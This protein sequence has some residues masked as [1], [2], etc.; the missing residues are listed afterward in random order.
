[1]PH[2]RNGRE[3]QKGDVVWLRATVLEVYAS[4]TACNV[5]VKIHAPPGEPEAELGHLNTKSLYPG[6]VEQFTGAIDIPADVPRAI[7]VR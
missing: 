3:V 5:R 2:D 1:M 4:E 6:A 7:E